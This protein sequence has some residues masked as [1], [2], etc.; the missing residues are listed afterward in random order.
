[1]KVFYNPSYDGFV[2][3]DFSKKNIAFDTVVCNTKSLV[4]LIELHAGLYTS[5]ASD[6][7]RTLDYYN[8]LK[9]YT[10]ANP[11]HMFAA[12][13]DRDGINT[14]KECLKW[15]DSMLL[16]GW[17]PGKNDASQR[18][19]TLASIEKDFDSPSFG[20]KLLNVTKALKKGLALPADLE[21]IIPFDY[22]CFMPAEKELLKAIGLEKVH[23]NA[24]AE[25]G[26]NYLAK[27]A[28]V[29]KENTSEKLTLEQNDGSVDIIQ[30]ETQ[31]ESLEYLSQL[32]PDAYDVWI[33][34]DNRSFDNWLSYLHKPTCGAYDKGVSQISELPLIG[35]GLFS[36]PLNLNS[37]LSWLSVPLNPLSKGFR[38]KLIE[39]IVGAGGYFNEACRACID[40][41]PDY[42]KDAIKYF[43]PDITKPQEAISQNEK[44]KKARIVEYVSELSKWIMGKFKDEKLNENQ[45]L[46][47]KGALQTCN[48]MERILD[49]FEQD[50]IAFEEL[51]LVF[52]SLSTEIEIE[53]SDAKNGCANLI[54]SSANFACAAKSTIWCDFY[55]PD[56]PSLTYDFLLPSEK[57]ALNDLLWQPEDERTFNRLNKYL[58]FIF[59]KEKLTLVT[60]KKCGTT[61]TVPEPLIIRLEKNM[62][63]DEN[64][65]PLLDKFIKH[66]SLADIHGIKTKTLAQIQNRGQSEEG[67]INFE[68]TDLVHFRDSESFSSISNLIDNPFD[69]VFDKIIHLQKQGAAALSAVYTTK[70]TVAHAIIQELFGPVGG[71]TQTPQEIKKQID[72]RYEEVF[73]QKVLEKGGI[74][75][76]SENLSETAIFKEQMLECVKSLAGLLEE[77]NLKVVECEQEHKD[78]A[79]EDFKKQKIFFNGNIDMVLQDENGDSVIFDFKYSTSEKKY[80]EWISKNRSMQLALYKGLVHKATGKHAKAAAYILLPEVKVITADDLKG[81]IFKT[82]VDADRAGNLLAEMA[83]SYD[84]RKAQI[85]DG[86]VEDGEGMIFTYNGKIEN[87]PIDYVAKMEEQDLVPMDL[88]IHSKNK[89]WNKEP[90]SYS[91]Y[92]IFKAGE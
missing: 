59:T 53:I 12:S 30:F 50:E 9:A 57:Q 76:Q 68:R 22:N 88:E 49:I 69:Y 6:L 33:N 19:K 66:L 54:K 45:V 77:N 42:D 86:I 14:A 90:N 10:K 2:Y 40:D 85:L 75:L 28:K 26:S 7:D 35:L 51:I 84:F 89:T 43:L 92:S 78:A 11:G 63:E 23:V 18:M 8:A 34:R 32:R 21:I 16:A 62:G 82:A 41:A 1:M 70:G 48:A 13:F 55:N 5:L 79:L 58:P 3:F 67:T 38:N 47:L 37:L 39:A 83:N 52:D 29:L 64:K 71:G 56:Q 74:L 91:N 61:D 46:H 81:A 20:E 4:N 17:E 24:E 80:G 31:N 73:N 25:A 44:I 72:T 36:R 27:M 15:R 87:P 60:V 65:K